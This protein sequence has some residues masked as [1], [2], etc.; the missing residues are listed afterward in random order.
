MF[1][2]ISGSFPR[3]GDGIGDAAGR[4][5]AS[6]KDKAEICLVTSGHSQIKEYVKEQKY[7]NVH[8]VPN[9]RIRTVWNLLKMAQKKEITQILIEYCGNGYGKDLAISF[10]PLAIRL[11]NLFFRKKLECH[12]RLHEYTMC[13]PA[14]DRKS[15][16]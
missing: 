12:L 6:M 10:L 8:F 14:R 11:H 15:V 1:L 4:L 13:R 5:Y 16:V 2:Y 3:L 7:R 9:W